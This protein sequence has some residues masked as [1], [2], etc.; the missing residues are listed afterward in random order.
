M[1][2]ELTSRDDQLM[3]VLPVVRTIV[4]FPS[5]GQVE[6]DRPQPGGAHKRRTARCDPA[7]DDY[8]EIE[9]ISKRELEE[10]EAVG[11]EL[12]PPFT[13]CW[14]ESLVDITNP[15]PEGIGGS[16]QCPCDMK[17][18]DKTL[19]RFILHIR[20]VHQPMM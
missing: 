13:G 16:Y 6:G 5:L 17:F 4:Q 2:I 12:R 3:T 15:Q 19:F 10:R 7:A 18:T 9:D 20:R 11:R 1:V 8:E 14:T